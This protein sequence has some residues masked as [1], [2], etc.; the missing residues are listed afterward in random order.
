MVH[1][2]QT[3]SRLDDGPVKITNHRLT[4]HR[5]WECSRPPMRINSVPPWRYA[6][7]EEKQ[8]RE[9]REKYE[10]DK[11]AADR[12]AEGIQAENVGG[13]RRQTTVPAD[14]G[15]CVPPRA[16]P[17]EHRRTDRWPRHAGH[18]K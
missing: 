7:R 3:R 10:R 15:R 9:Q 4:G 2:S 12:D 16:S 1:F 6:G 8:S 11:K 18:T 13:E 5:A 14:D 17:L